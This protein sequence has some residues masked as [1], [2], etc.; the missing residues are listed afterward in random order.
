MFLIENTVIPL[1][2]HEN[3]HGT[4]IMGLLNGHTYHET[5]IIMGQ[6]IHSLHLPILTMNVPM[7]SIEKGAHLTRWASNEVTQG[8]QCRLKMENLP[9]RNA[10]FSWIFIDFHGFSLATI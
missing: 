8:G 2:H 3:H 9:D 4:N 7:P 6:I 1:K 10:G 5:S